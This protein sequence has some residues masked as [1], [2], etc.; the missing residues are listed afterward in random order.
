MKK[1]GI[2]QEL[3]GHEGPI[4]ITH[5]A[6]AVTINYADMWA[7]AEAAGVPYVDDAQDFN[8]GHGMSLWAKY[9]GPDGKRQD[10]AH[11]YIHPL[12]QSGKYPNLHLL[13][14]S[15]VSKV[16]FD[17]ARA[18]GVEYVPTSDVSETTSS[19]IAAKKLVIVSAGALATAPI[20]ERSGVGKAEHLRA[21]GI[22]VVSDLPGVGENYQDHHL[23]IYPYKSTW[24]SKDSYDGFLSGREDFAQALADNSTKT[25]WN[26]IDVCGKIRP[27]EDEVAQLGSEFQ[28]HWDR[29]YKHQPSRPL[30]IMPML[31]GYLGDHAALNEPADNPTHYITTASFMTY[32]RSRGSVHINSTDPKMA[33]SFNTGFL[34]DE[35]DVKVQVW[36]YKKQREIIRRSDRYAGE[37]APGHPAFRKGSRAACQSGPAVEGGFESMEQRRNLPP[38][39]YD[40]EDDL[41]IAEFI[42][43]NIGSS[44]HSLGTCKMAPR[45]SGGVV[46]KHL[47]VHGTQNLKCAGKLTW[48]SN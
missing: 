46:D 9:I 12:M 41:A 24:T 1:D 19:F 27:S 37:Y 23:V 4:N 40:E 22:E 29:D 14:K 21:H 2:N 11:C 15:T 31:N 10:A 18:I 47:N 48:W 8:Q 35:F 30:F 32:P 44:W 17:G 39:E 45:E 38:I 34:N 20:L 36:A 26:A 42:R 43:A 7:G 28:A 5:G 3:H 6:H 16:V 13:V 25:S 33:P